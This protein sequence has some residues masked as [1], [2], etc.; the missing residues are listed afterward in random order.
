VLPSL[1]FTVPLA[2]LILPALLGWAAWLWLRDQGNLSRARHRVALALRLTILTALALVLAGATYQQPETRQATVFVADLSAST[3]GVQDREA[4]FIDRALKAR[5]RDDV[6]AVVAVGGDAQVEQGIARPSGFTAFAS[7]VD[8]SAT[9]LEA[10]LN[11]AG[12]LFPTGYRKRVVLLTDGQQNVGDALAAARLLHDEGVRLD[13][14]PLT[15]AGGPEALV[16]N[17]DVPSTLHKGDRVPLTVFLNSTV[18]QTGT[19]DVYD[20]ARHVAR[21]PVALAA[22]GTRV[23]VPLPPLGPGFHRLRVAL[24]APLDTVAGNDEG[25]AVTHVRGAPIILVAEGA[26]GEGDIVAASLRAKGMTVAQES[27]VQ[28]QASAEYLGRFDGVVLVDAPALELDPALLD[29]ARSPLHAYVDG[30]GGLVV[31]G[32]PTSYGVGGYTDTA[33]DDLLPVSM[34]LPQRKDTPAVAVALIIENLETESNVNISKAAGEGVVRLLTPADRVEVNDANGTDVPGNGW[35]VPLQ[36]VTNKTLIDRAIDA[37]QPVDPMSYVPALNAA[38]NSLSHTNAKIKHII[39]L[40]DGDATDDYYAIVH[41]IYKAGITVSTVATGA[42]SFGPSNYGVMQ[43][44]ARWG[45]GHYYQSDNVANIPQIFLKETK[46]IARTGLVEERFTPEYISASPIIAGLPGAPLDGYVATTPK[47]Q[48]NQVLVHVTKHGLDPILSQWQYGLGR[49][50]AWTSDARGQWTANIVGSAQGNALWANMVS[51]VL[52]PDSSPNLSFSASLSGGQ[53]HLTVTT[54]GLPLDAGVTARIDGPARSS[55][56]TLQPTA[57]GQYE[58]DVPAS[59][60][61]AYLVGIRAHGTSGAA[62]SLRTSFVVPYAPEYRAT[63]LNSH[64]VGDAA[65]AGDGALMQESAAGQSFADNLAPVY[66]PLPLA[67]WLLLL[68]LLLLPV[69]VAAR[70]LLVGPAEVREALAALRARRA[71]R[72]QPVGAGAL[73]TPVGTAAAPLTTLRARRSTRQERVA[74]GAAAGQQPA[75]SVARPALT[76][77]TPSMTPRPSERRRPGEMAVANPAP[78]PS[79]PSTPSPVSTPDAATSQSTPGMPGTPGAA[80]VQDD[81]MSRLLEA[82]RRR[83][84]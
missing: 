23:P 14:V 66:A 35:A 2:L 12:A 56:L 58:A 34:R 73:M 32:G 78:I 81:T 1:T 46:Q 62:P 40:G 44:I 16:S 84:R 71:R 43:D 77:V 27:A 4:A 48:G 51:W 74:T 7:L 37:M 22:G 10:G 15:P 19:L 5:G 28:V 53:A 3:A 30:G 65:A 41:K 59:A 75:A 61:G 9:S 54:T 29:P 39:L 63:G 47:P 49:V 60:T 80:G 64:L 57:P 67:T 11:L 8:R 83:R 6:A 38:Y 42:G 26:P 68:A 36:Y 25:E 33:L 45:H 31:I 70:R 50:V 17:V 20:D 55:S 24:N 21:V 18:A 76:P 72:L 52:P 79:T 69:D 13:V 82:K